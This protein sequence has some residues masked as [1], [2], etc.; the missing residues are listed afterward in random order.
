MHHGIIDEVTVDLAGILPEKADQL[1]AAV[2]GLR[3]L[4]FPQR[5]RGAGLRRLEGC[6]L[7]PECRAMCARAAPEQIG[8]LRMSS[9]GLTLADSRPIATSP[10]LRTDELDFG[11]NRRPVGGGAELR[12]RRR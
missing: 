1:F 9:L 11:Y 12:S 10:N 6:P 8:V 3:V 7:Q 2:P 5:P 4:A